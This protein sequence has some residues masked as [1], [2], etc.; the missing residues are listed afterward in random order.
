MRNNLSEHWKPSVVSLEEF[1]MTCILIGTEMAKA[2]ETQQNGM[3]IIAKVESLSFSQA[4]Q[5]TP[6]L[7]KKFVDIV[8]V[9]NEIIMNALMFNLE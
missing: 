9:R 5:V 7:V 8:Y 4:R 1:L 2:I 3:V 6:A